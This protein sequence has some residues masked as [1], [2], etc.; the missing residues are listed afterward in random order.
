MNYNPKNLLSIVERSATVSHL[1]DEFISWLTGHPDLRHIYF[2]NIKKKKLPH[3]VSNSPTEL[4][5]A[6]I[7]RSILIDGHELVHARLL[8]H[9]VEIFHPPIPYRVIYTGVTEHLRILPTIVSFSEPFFHDF[10]SYRGKVVPLSVINA[11]KKV[12]SI[13]EEEYWDRRGVEVG[14]AAQDVLLAYV[15]T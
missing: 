2:D 1:D 10:T 8:V 15:A 7:I 14:K 9:D 11:I 12:E 4:Q 13:V 5:L 6:G 3:P